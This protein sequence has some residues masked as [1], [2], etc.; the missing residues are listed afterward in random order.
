MFNE[1]KISPV[2]YKSS[3]SEEMSD[4][5]R[6]DEYAETGNPSYLTPSLARKMEVHPDVMKEVLG[7]TDEDIMF[8]EVMLEEN[9]HQFF[10]RTESLLMPLGADDE[11]LEKLDIHQK[12]RKLLDVATI[13]IGSI[14]DE[15]RLSHETISDCAIGKIGML[16][17]T[18]DESTYRLFEVLQMNSPQGFRDLHI[19]E[20]VIKRITHLFNDGDKNIEIVLR[21]LLDVANRMK[22]VKFVDDSLYLGS[23]YLGE[24]LELHGG[25]GDKDKLDSTDTY[26]PFE[27]TKDVYALF[28]EDKDRIFIA[29]HDLSSN[30]KDT[31]KT[32]W[33][34]EFMGPEGHDLPSYKYEYIPED[35]LDF[36]D[37]IFNAGILLDDYIKSLGIKAGLEEVKDYVTMLRSP[38]RR[39]IEENFGFRLTALSVVEQFYFL[40]YLKHTTVSTVKTMQEFIHH[41]GVDAMRS[42]LATIYDKNASE[43]IMIFG[44]MIDQDTAKGMFKSYAESIDKA[45]V[46]AKKLNIS[47]RNDVLLSTLLLEFKQGMIKRAGHL[48]DAGKQISLSEYGGEEETVDL[49]A[50]YEGVAKILSVLSDV[51]DDKGYIVTQVK[52]ETGGDTTMQTFKFNINEFETN[53]LFKLKVSIRPESTTKGEARINFELS[54]DELPEENELKKAF[55]QTIQF[56][57]NNGRNAR[58]VTGSVIRFG[59]DLDTRTEPPAFSFDMGRDSYVS[60]DMERTGDVLGRILAQVAPT[61][62]HL[63]DFNQ[64]LSSPKNFAKV[65][66]VF[67]HYFERIK[68]TS[69]AVQ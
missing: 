29:D 12:F 7:A 57:G 19:V 41:Y 52:K 64:S 51:G 40:N 38:I 6:I 24:F 8:A 34:S 44:T 14:R 63:Q 2:V 20:E 48:F 3:E 35:L 59:F 37:D 30:I 22:D 68:P 27:I 49:I 9:N 42:F 5:E 4:D 10:S 65:A 26:V 11:S 55:Q 15:E 17:A 25:Y 31:I 67:I 58:T 33:T 61:G 50:A 32:D 28:T 66:E 69:D 13:R 46:L 21:E 62:H 23:V 16:L 54:L 56:K 18:E 47:D 60:D 36:T 43:N 1:N 39:V 53:N 45:N